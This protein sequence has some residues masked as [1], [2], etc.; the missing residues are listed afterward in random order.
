VTIDTK[1]SSFDTVMGVYGN[2]GAL[3]LLAAMMIEV[4]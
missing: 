3:A 1:G 4:T 2:V